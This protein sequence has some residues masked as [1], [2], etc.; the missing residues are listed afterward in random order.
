M[1]QQDYK[2][3][4]GGGEMGA[5][6]RAH[7][8]SQTSLGSPDHWP[9]SLRTA[10]G[11]VLNSRFPMFMYWGPDLICFYNDAYRP[12]LGVNGKHPT[13]LGQ[14]G[15][16]FWAEIWHILEPL[17][18]QVLSGGGATW[19]EDQ[20]IP[21]YRNGAI[22]DIYWTFSYSPVINEL[23]EPAGII[24]ACTETTEKVQTLSE[25]TESK[26]E[27]E[28]AIDSAEFGTWDMN[29]QTNKFIA[30]DRLKEWFGLLPREEIDLTQALKSVVAY[31]R[32]RVSR[33]IQAV[34]NPSSGGKYD[35]EYSLI[36]PHTQTERVVRAKGRTRFNEEGVAIRFNGT[37]QDITEEVIARR[38]IEDAEERARLALD[39]AEMG[40]FDLSLTTG[41]IITSPRF[42]AIFGED[43]PTPHNRIIS[44]LHPDDRYIRERAYAQALKTGSLYYAVRIVLKDGRTRWIEVEGKVYYDKLRS[45]VRLLGTVIDITKQRNAEE[46]LTRVKFMA[47]NASDVFML[48]CEE[49]SFAYLN[50]EAFKQWGY[51]EEEGLKLKV[52][53]I[54]VL[55]ISEIFHESF[56]LAQTQT[57]PPFETI[58][59]RKNETVYPVEINMVG[60]VLSEKPYLFAVAR[61]ITERKKAR[62]EQHKT[63]QRLEIALEAGRLGSYELELATGLMTCTPQ[64]KANYGLDA[65]ATFNFADLMAAIQ[66]DYRDTVKDKVEAAVANHS[67]YSAEYQVK[68]PNGSIHWVSASGKASYD[69]NDKAILMVGVTID[70][71]E[72]KLLQQQKDEFIGIA[73]HELKTPVT[74]IKAYTQVLER[75][76]T[77][78]GDTREASM[79]SKMDAQ[80]N[81]LNSLIGDL[82]D[83]TK[84]NSGR[85]QFNYTTFDFNHLITEVVEDLQRT[86]EKHNLIEDLQPTG[87]I[88]ADRE[89]ISQV[90]VN[91]I[92]NA[93]KYSPHTK[94][95]IINTHLNND[96]V[97]VS[98]QDFG[99]GISKE[100]QQRVFEQFY[101]VSGET[102]H[103]FPGLGLGLYISSEIIKREG[104]RI[105]V[106]SEEGQGS[107]FY[108]SLPVRKPVDH[109]N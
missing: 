11:I 104:G 48:I 51:S 64:C 56:K 49:G 89:R 100:K 53:D 74:S 37:M 41:S 24:V 106:E 105:W 99:I 10:L 85:L 93:I 9:V 87:F 67:V 1:Q 3:W 5:L 66:P 47:D 72:Q 86:T 68:W 65:N 27:L 101:R 12:S 58:H 39:A 8:W 29:P 57:L 33:A 19:S 34:M 61:D 7:D 52:S 81:R 78:K 17:I 73:S 102:Q 20:L 35:I 79:I 82:L 75:I 15:K 107:I 103:T 109:N 40:T 2:F 13:L 50:Q 90:L 94:N 6:I 38:K 46:E 16:V 96:E 23:G 14:P 25:I 59:K 63:N 91:F 80:L 4:Q 42:N 28:F 84:I 71:T 43:G 36:D 18:N 31:D 32:E 98:V 55:Y 95:I 77:Q 97:V 88:H 54:D 21:F 108:F 62:E 70:I 92:T 45:P 76:L 22:E 83:V 44:K 30:N 69:E 60:L 26:A